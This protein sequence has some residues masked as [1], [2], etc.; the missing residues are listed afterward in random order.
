MLFL[1]IEFPSP[2]VAF[3]PRPKVALLPR[4]EIRLC[5]CS[6]LVSACGEPQGA[7][8]GPFFFLG[9]MRFVMRVCIV[10]VYLPSKYNWPFYLSMDPF[11][12][13][14]QK[15]HAYSPY[16]AVISTGAWGS[17]CPTRVRLAKQCHA[18]GNLLPKSVSSCAKPAPWDSHS[19]QVSGTQANKTAYEMVQ[20]ADVADVVAE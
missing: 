5:S 9:V 15:A 18:F 2:K 11:E 10:V 13:D 19:K 8:Q 1:I 6:A 20:T 14:L 4:P 16:Q 3:G 17:L 12:S 7:C